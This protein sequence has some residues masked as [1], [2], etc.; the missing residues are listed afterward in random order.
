[1]GWKDCKLC[2]KFGIGFG[3]ILLLL[4]SSGGWSIFGING[5]VGNAEEVIAGNKLR[6][7]FTQR[8]VD[9]LKWSE[10]VNKLLTD[11]TM[12]ELNVQ[13]DPRKCAFGK[14]YYSDARTKAEAL[15]PGI[16]PMLR[17]IEAHHNKLH[18]SAIDIAKAY[19]P[20]D[21][22][23]SGFLRE[24]KLDHLSWMGKI[25]DALINPEA[26]SSNVQTD[27]TRCSLGK[28]L[29]SQE[30]Q[31]HMQQDP[32]FGAAVKSILEPHE[33]LHKSA[34]E[35][36]VYLS[37]YDKS[38]AQ[39]FFRNNTAAKAKETLAAIDKVLTLLDARQEGYDKAKNI[40]TTTTLP[41]LNSVQA[42]LNSSMDTLASNIMTDQEMLK[43]ADKTL[44]G[45]MIF[46]VVSVI[47]GVFLASVIGRGIIGPLREGMDFAKTIATGDLRATVDIQ[48]GD[49]V[50]QLAS[51][52]TTMA[53]KL[54]HVVGNVNS[55][56]DSVSAGSE[57]LSASAE[58]LSQSVTEQA[59]TIEE[60]S[61]SMEEMS[62]GVRSNT[63]N[64]RKTEDIAASAAAGAK[65]SGTAVD[66]ALGALKSIAER[67]T[68]I[69]DIARQTN[70]LA[71]NAA[72]EAA[73]AGEHGKGFAVVAA[74]VR[75]LA[76]RSGQAAEEI[77]DLSNA[78][79][80]VADKAG[81]M[82]QELVPQIGKTAELI[83]EI[84]TSCAEQDKGV[85]EIS[86]SV[87]QLDQI[88]QTNAS[89]AEEM[90]STSEE[91][92]AQ[93][94]MLA[95]TMTFFTVNQNDA[96]RR[97]PKVV[98]TQSAPARGLPQGQPKPAPRQASGGGF[99]MNMDDEDFERF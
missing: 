38:D 41:A 66:E 23:L 15:V 76:E 70:L 24:K 32:E 64:A 82:L 62:A 10:E 94:Q 21:A 84:A 48:Q 93:A 55:A 73:R 39:A 29:Y 20:A 46:A 96:T 67:I 50:G 61:A 35:I 26:T 16:K 91:L 71:L 75:K 68:I 36:D 53:G 95:Q 92:S 72:I 37:N 33:Q 12:H 31:R 87:G 45:V 9:H 90:A 97:G 60:I 86:T 98:R 99:D 83:K 54:N 14:W 43:E 2:M 17:E 40:Y 8:V 25:K 11:D 81:S 57:E 42:L 85:S 79:M 89:A 18:Q 49:E 51:S 13:T 88:I 22:K 47:L 77:G 69:Q 27:P 65:D 44:T 52:L 3:T 34:T 78:S 19:A 80:G 4:V 7:N 5:I 28:W 74:E 30:T 6:G 58:A 56:T 59:A 63:E 1:M